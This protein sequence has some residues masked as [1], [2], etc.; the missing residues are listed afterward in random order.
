MKLVCSAVV[1]NGI[2]LKMELSGLH[3]GDPG[4][5]IKNSNRNKITIWTTDSTCVLFE[6]IKK[7][8]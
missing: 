7:S 8:L 3:M 1:E 2:G 4:H 5:R 6:S